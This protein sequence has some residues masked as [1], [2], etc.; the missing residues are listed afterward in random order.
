MTDTAGPRPIDPDDPQRRAIALTR[1]GLHHYVATSQAT[2]ASIEFGKGD[3]LVTPVELLLAAIAGCTGYD[4][5]GPATRRSEPDTFEADVESRMLKDD[6]G[7][8]HLED[9]TVTWHLRYPDTEG[10]RQAQ[11]L[12]PQLL[13]QSHDRLCTVSITIERG[14]PITNIL[15]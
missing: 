8:Q 12:L 3:G 6:A 4:M 5:D 14:T 11:Q 2:G 7:A 15:D 13:R 9:I 10:G 1:K